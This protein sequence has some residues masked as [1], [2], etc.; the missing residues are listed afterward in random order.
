MRFYFIVAQAAVLGI[1]QSLYIY[2]CT[3]FTVERI[4]GGRI[5]QLV[6][7]LTGELWNRWF[8][9]CPFLGITK[10]T[11][12]NDFVIRKSYYVGAGALNSSWFFGCAFW[13]YFIMDPIEFLLEDYTPQW[14]SSL[15]VR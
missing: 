12:F 9:Y 14:M 5:E 7:G 8:S 13:E 1:F 6:G 15:C 4:P 3:G 11:F 10:A 2:V